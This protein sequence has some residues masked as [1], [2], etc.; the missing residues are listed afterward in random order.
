MFVEDHEVFAAAAGSDRE[1]PCLVCE[2]GITIIVV[3]DHEVFAAAT[4]SDGE[5]TCLVCGDIAG[6]FD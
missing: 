6:Y 4:G 2:D 3:E 1:T 5:T